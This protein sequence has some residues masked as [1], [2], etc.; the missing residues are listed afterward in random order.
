MI[1]FIFLV[2]WAA[3]ATLMSIFIPNLYLI[4]VW[5]VTGYIVSLIGVVLFVAIN[6][7]T[8]FPLTKVDNKLKYMTTRS[9]AKFLNIFVLRLKLQI[10]G[11]ENI[12]ATGRLT[13]YSNHKSY[14]DPI[15]IEHVIKRA[16]TY[17]PK[18]GVYK[19]PVV[20]TWLKSIGAFP[21]DRE[22]T[23]NTARAL[24]DAIKV[25]KGG[26]N[27]AIFPE[28]GIKDRYDNK[29]VEMRAGA[30]KLAMKA[31]ADLLPITLMNTPQIKHRAPW[32]STVIKVIVHPVVPYE[33]V[34]DMSTAEVGDYMFHIINEPFTKSEA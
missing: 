27:M 5:I 16:T 18:T 11:R 8:W 12:P 1:S 30:Y 25:V 20:K 34:K 17:T 32:R 21:I 15:I 2:L 7:Y 29:M 14:A 10:E 13:T 3:Y 24:V 22:N 4:P 9:I 31:K 6:I 19:L 26:M 28:G 23:R 33:R